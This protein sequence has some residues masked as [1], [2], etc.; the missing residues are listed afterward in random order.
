[1]VNCCLFG[2]TVW[3]LVVLPMFEMNMLPLSSGRKWLEW[4]Y[5]QG[6]R[7]KWQDIIT[8]KMETA[9]SFEILAAWR[10]AAGYHDAGLL[11][12]HISVII[13]MFIN[14]C[15]RTYHLYRVIKKSVHL[16]IT[17]QKDTSNVQSVPCQSPDIYWHVELC[18][19]RPCSV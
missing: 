1:M 2:S 9:C 4:R 3:N 12:C 16:M 15:K 7:A 19:W 10:I 14:I 17:I 13:V 18:S 6:I 5:N 11:R 8:L